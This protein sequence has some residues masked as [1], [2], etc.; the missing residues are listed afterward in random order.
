MDRGLFMLH[1]PMLSRGFGVMPALTLLAARVMLF[2]GT[3][4][5][6]CVSVMVR[7][8]RVDHVQVEAETRTKLSS[9]EQA[10]EPVRPPPSVSPS[11]VA[12]ICAPLSEKAADESVGAGGIESAVSTKMAW[13]GGVVKFFAWGPV[14]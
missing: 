13:G 1:K 5:A 6:P 8:E 2:F 12:M 4:V 11:K 3:M 9:C 14:R 7:V 10:K